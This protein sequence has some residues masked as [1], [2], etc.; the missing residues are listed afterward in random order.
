MQD[1]T[2]IINKTFFNSEMSYIEHF[3]V[4]I[5]KKSK[6]SLSKLLFVEVLCLFQINIDINTLR[7]TSRPKNS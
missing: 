7:G 6:V 5:L 4:T 2:K 1:K 3:L